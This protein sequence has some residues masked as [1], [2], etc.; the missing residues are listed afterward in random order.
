LI[1]AYGLKVIDGQISG[2]IWILNRKKE[3]LPGGHIEGVKWRGASTYRFGVSLTGG[4]QR[5]I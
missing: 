2:Q 5:Q 4:P 3:N 1:W